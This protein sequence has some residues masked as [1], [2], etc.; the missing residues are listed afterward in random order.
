VTV[1]E[2]E[3]LVG[4]LARTE[5]R[6]GFRFDLGGHRFFTKHPE[7]QALWEEILGDELIVRPRLSRIRYGGRMFAYP[8]DAM[9]VVR[10]LGP[11]ELSRALGSYLRARAASGEPDTFAEWVTRRFGRR[12]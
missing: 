3:S 9:D 12:L 11:L 4:G 5:E 10:N 8:L 7:V 1:L 6:D 2:R